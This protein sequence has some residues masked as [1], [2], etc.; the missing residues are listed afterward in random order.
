MAQPV[1]GRLQ[2]AKEGHLQLV[3][4]VG[5]PVKGLRNKSFISYMLNNTQ[6]YPYPQLFPEDIKLMSRFSR[7]IGQRHLSRVKGR[8]LLTYQGGF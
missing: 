3:K 5:L 6:S 7:V 2:L 4:V 1:D 8:V